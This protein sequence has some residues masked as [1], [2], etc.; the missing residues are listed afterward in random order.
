MRL[1][2]NVFAETV[3]FGGFLALLIRHVPIMSDSLPSSER[4]LKI[5]SQFGVDGLIVLFSAWVALAARFGDWWPRQV[6]TYWPTLAIASIVLPS[7]IYIFGLYSVRGLHLRKRERLMLLLAAYCI[8]MVLQMAMGSIDFSSRIGRG[9]LIL[10]MPLGLVLLMVHHGVLVRRGLW[11]RRQVALVVV[12]ERDE[13]VLRGAE[14]LKLTLTHVVGYFRAEPM[15][16][17]TAAPYLGGVAEIAKVM[18]NSGIE[19]LVCSHDHLRSTAM[20]GVLREVC[21]SGHTVLTL[22]DLLEEAYE[23][24][25]LGMVDIEWLVMASSMP[26]RRYAKKV[27]RLFDVI[28]SVVVGLCSLPV[29]LSGYLLVRLTS[30]GPIFYRQVRCG[31]Y[32]RKFEVWK[33]R[34]MKV[35][36]EKNGVQWSAGSRDPRL[37]PFGGLL[38]KFRIDE[39]PQLWNILTGDMSFVGPRPERPTFVD[40]LAGEIPFYKER[41]LVQPGLTGWAQVCYPY[42]ASV[43]DAKR[44]LEY[45]LYYMKHMSLMLDLFILLDT[46]RTVLRGGAKRR[47][48]STLFEI[49]RLLT[50]E[51]AMREQIA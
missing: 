12:S 47:S 7:V 21:F 39:I 29:F 50:G 25:P 2:F 24:V 48:N 46:V 49:D 31:R 37:T 23:A 40:Q 20:A 51:A 14:S 45:D 44:K 9:V 15:E 41:L 8:T 22:T 11:K 5:R 28:T 18:E 4:W 16:E 33:L 1:G 6:V 30:P 43:E 17:G 35:D 13:Q 34:T 10:Q 36:A 38:R 27:K 26:R 42:G 32:G 3:D 19:A